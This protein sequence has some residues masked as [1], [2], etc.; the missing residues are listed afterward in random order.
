MVRAEIHA[1]HLPPSVPLPTGKLL[2]PVGDDGACM[3][4]EAWT[5]QI[6]H[7]IPLSTATLTQVRQCLSYCAGVLADVL[8]FCKV[9]SSHCSC[10]RFLRT[11]EGDLFG[12]SYWSTGSIPG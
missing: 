2:A 5:L 4:A 9:A 12:G 1:H 6:T 10:P 8:V 11:P 7:T 3:A